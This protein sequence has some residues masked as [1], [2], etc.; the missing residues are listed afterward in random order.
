VS[1]GIRSMTPASRALG[2]RLRVGYL[3]V[4]VIVAGGFAAAGWQ[5]T[6][7]L[8]TNSQHERI[9][10][11]ASRQSALSLRAA[12]YSDSLFFNPL[13][14]T[15]KIF[16]QTITEWLD[17]ENTLEGVLEP[18]CGEG[19]PLCERFKQLKA[20]RSKM[21]SWLRISA[22][23]RTVA[24][25]EVNGRARDAAMDEYSEAM[26]VWTE[27][28]AKRL[29]SASID[30]QRTLYVWSLLM[31]L[32]AG[33][34]IILVLEPRI[35]Q[36]QAERSIIDRWTG[37]RE[38]LANVAERTHHSVFLLDPY[39]R[40]EWANEAFLR[41]VH[42][43]LKQAEGAALLD[44]LPELNLDAATRAQL[45]LSVVSGEAFQFDLQYRNA[46]GEQRWGAVDCRPIMV[47]G[48][49][50]S[51]FAIESDITERKQSEQ[52]I[53]QQRAMLAATAGLAGVG[54]WQLDFATETSTWSDTLF[55]IHEMPVGPVPSIDEVLKFFPGEARETVIRAMTA[56]RESGLASDFEAPFI[57]ATGKLRWMRAIVYAQQVNG[58]PV[59]LIG[60][61][62]DITASRQAAEQLRNAK[63]A[64]DAANTAKGLFLANMSHEIRTPL[65][66]VIGMTDLLLDTQL[67]EQQREYA[68]IARSSGETLLALINDVLDISKIESGQLDLESI[69]F[70][71]AVLIEE[72]LDAVA[73]KASD[74]RLE[75]LADVDLEVPTRLRGDPTRLRQVLLNLLS[76]AVKF[77]S[78]GEVT[79]EVRR[80][81]EALD[82]VALS[83]RVI[84][85]GIGI[86][87]EAIDKLFTP[88]TQEDASTTRRH[89]GTGLGLSICRRLIEAM[90]GNIY[91]ASHVGEGSAFNFNLQFHLSQGVALPARL[92]LP[93]W[94][95][96][97]VAEHPAHLRI[98]NARLKSWTFNVYS[99]ASAPEG[100]KRWQELCAMGRIPEVVMID[101]GLPDE[102]AFWLGNAIRDL[103]MHRHSRLILLSALNQ[104]V[105]ADDR[106]IFEHIVTK[107][108]KWSA[109]Q[110]LLAEDATVRLPVLAQAEVP[111]RASEEFLGRRVLLVDDNAVNR[112]VGE[113]LLQKMGATV[114]LAVNGREALSRLHAT[115]FDVVLMDCQMPEMDGY[116]ATRQI[117]GGNEIM[118]PEIPVI[119][120]TANALSGDREL[121]IA[122]GMN[123]YL[124]KPID[125][126]RLAE[127]LR[128]ALDP[129]DAPRASRRMR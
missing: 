74:K 107:P 25:R 32:C 40:I 71:L 80:S 22:E 75:L 35:R 34:V 126:K 89:G 18:M 61:V 72:T 64:A 43:T 90:G 82:P 96:L 87:A 99:A 117:R 118:N 5:I 109:L 56:A 38:K 84:D 97:A 26:D 42:R 63:N 103:D 76:N 95:V 3:T 45:P 20:M 77:T 31:S 129:A 29:S 65:N 28:L 7:V 39:G 55:N 30:Q 27:Q 120:L 91:V 98:L 83:F 46:D 67:S 111:P 94:R 41:T 4:L 116:E 33:V 19:D 123:D 108:L 49:L 78:R 48:R 88:F 50:S 9:L 62:Q 14:S 122:A 125:P 86:A 11:I 24:E 73:L 100:L 70:D 79:L 15:R 6:R 114:E 113:R 127:S 36:L 23:W 60:A 105:G 112:K 16:D 54:G 69:D 119:A 128:A 8:A 85:T 47:D 51:F 101:R 53:A 37:E 106:A 58:L 104:P 115:H 93:A 21:E 81:G 59:G 13:A 121:C 12:D 52:V 66:G 57:T 17:D 44:L 102:Q 10:G 124:T 68:D 110:K 1:H 2:R 92:E